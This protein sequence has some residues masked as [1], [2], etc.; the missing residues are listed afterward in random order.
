MPLL[1]RRAGRIAGRPWWVVACLAL[2][3]GIAMA[4]G[5]GAPSDPGADARR[6]RDLAA[7][8]LRRGV[9][10]LRALREQPEARRQLVVR[11]ALDEALCRVLTDQD[12]AEALGVAEAGLAAAGAHP[13]AASREPWLRLRACRAGMLLESGQLAVGQ[14]ELEQLLEA[15]R[16]PA[17]A[18]IH[19][20]VLLERGVYRSRIG[21]LEVAQTDLMRAC[22]T[23][24]STGPDRDLTL[25]LGHLANHYR[26]VGDGEE[27]LKLLLP[28]RDAAR[29]RGETYDDGIYTFGI[30]QVLHSLRRLAEANVAYRESSAS[31]A[32]FDDR[33]GVGFSE[34]GLAV[35]LLQLGQPAQALQH[36]ERSLALTPQATAP[37]QFEIGSI[38]RAEVLVALGRVEPAL[39]ALDS[40][41][42]AVRRRKEL[43]MMQAWWQVRSQA[44]RALG[45]W[46][47]AY[48]ALA[49]ANEVDKTLQ[50]QRLSGQSA[51]LRMQFNRARDAEE[52]SI[53]RKLNEQGHRLRQAQA[54]ALAMF[55]IVLSIVVVVAW[56][57]LQRSRGL[58][59]LAST[60]ELTG[61]LNRRSL[62]EFSGQALHQ[63]QAS[64]T[65]LAVLMIDVD[66]FKRIN[67]THGHAVGDQVLRNVA[68]TL[69][70][71]LRGQD[72]LGRVGGEE[73][74]AVL[75]GSSLADAAQVAE[76]MRS[77]VQAMPT[78]V[79]S[80]ALP[81]TVSLGVAGA[82]GLASAEA[83]VALGDAAL[84][85]AKQDG[86]NRVAVSD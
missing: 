68:N 67:D 31:F 44:M 62:F 75:P 56:R 37:R 70:A 74:V 7:A 53:L 27:A 17:D 52:L 14:A 73:F 28:L 40:I 43:S 26:R 9:A 84:Y 82:E 25:C 8:D 78:P 29:G 45:R 66:H 1:P 24:R 72:R 41:G 21:Q 18:S 64:G 16:S 85:R 34:H 76:R 48:Q 69:G 50:E 46:Q 65:P 11:L 81:V 57:A 47:E 35:T 77:A 36:I 59:R 71:S 42:E 3:G 49:E 61:L 13:D 22:E 79:A 63:A 5:S 86:R 30:A 38:T 55:V 20:L 12:A 80:G 4:A 39:A 6:G 54:V 23:L 60:D 2:V 19:A 58:R 10:L 32:L 15:T 33:A 51:R 83:L